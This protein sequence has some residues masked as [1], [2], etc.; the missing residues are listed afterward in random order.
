MVVLMETSGGRHPTNVPANLMVISACFVAELPT[1]W[2]LN[3]A[4]KEMVVDVT[5]FSEASLR[6]DG[7][8]LNLSAQLPLFLYPF[9]LS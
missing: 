4:W 5:I 8:I 1:I 7:V 9:L 3:C 2:M 6:K